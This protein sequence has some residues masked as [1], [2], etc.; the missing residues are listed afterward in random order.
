MREAIE[1]SEFVYQVTAD[2]G[3]CYICKNCGHKIPLKNPELEKP[4][5]C[6]QCGFEF[7][8]N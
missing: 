7:E 3:V 4:K 5:K 1:K 2:G 6:P 8:N